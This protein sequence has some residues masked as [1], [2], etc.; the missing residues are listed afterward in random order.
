MLKELENFQK[1][2]QKSDIIL[3]GAKCIKKL[4]GGQLNVKSLHIS[5]FILGKGSIKKK[6]SMEFSIRGGGVPPDFGSVSILFF[7]F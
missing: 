3:G 6:K 2:H 5:V 4:K 1:W 7:Y